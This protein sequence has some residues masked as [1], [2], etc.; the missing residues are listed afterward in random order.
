MYVN[1][2]YL[3]YYNIIISIHICIYTCIIQYTY[4]SMYSCVM[5]IGLILNKYT[6]IL[7]FVMFICLYKLK[8]GQCGKLQIDHVTCEV[9]LEYFG[10]KIDFCWN[11]G[12]KK[13]SL[14]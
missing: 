13:L 7:A 9:T 1:I 8:F 2:C 4:F 3:W 11:F 10:G 14:A 5:E 12:K 6:I